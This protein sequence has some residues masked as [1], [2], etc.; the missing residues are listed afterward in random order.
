MKTLIK[1]VLFLAL[2][3][4]PL[5]LLA[6]STSVVGKWYTFDDADGSRKSI[7]E[8]KKGANGIYEG[9]IVEILT[10]N[11]DKRCV[12]CSG[13][14]KDKPILGL[15]I[16][17]KLKGDGQ[18]LSGGTILDPNNGKVYSCNI[19]LEEGG[20][21]LKVRGSLDRFGLLGRTQTW[22]RVGK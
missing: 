8:I 5:S 4:L 7:V 18:K 16:V 1:S 13:E 9:T 21:S 14:Y 6:Q 3:M 15:T 10:G 17:K 12:D 20:E 11:V 2:V 22:K 19:T